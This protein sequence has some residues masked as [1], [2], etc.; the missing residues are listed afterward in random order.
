MNALR[1]FLTILAIAVPLVGCQ[2]AGGWQHA[3]I[4]EEY[5][6]TDAAQCRYESRRR[7]EE[8]VSASAVAY[9]SASDTEMTVDTMMTQDRVSDRAKRY[10]G[11]CMSALGYEKAE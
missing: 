10:F 9:Q 2:T 1:P 5:W 6:S 4:A 7:A 11:N 8:R 3:S